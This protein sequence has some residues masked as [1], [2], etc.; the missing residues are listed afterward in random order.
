LVS[1]PAFAS[2][3]LGIITGASELTVIDCDTP[4]RREELEAIFGSADVVVATS[5]GGLHLYYKSNGEHSAPIDIN[6]MKI[7]VKGLGGFV[8]APPST[9]VAAD[10]MVRFYQ[11]LEGGWKW[12]ENLRAIKPGALPKKF[13]GSR[14]S[15]GAPLANKVG[16]GVRNTT[17]FNALLRR[18]K[19][20]E[21]RDE[22]LREATLI[23]DRFAQPLQTREVEAT[24]GSVW[25]YKVEG[26][27]IVPSAPK[28]QIPA[29]ALELLWNTAN[30]ADALMFLSVLLFNHG[31]RARRGEDFA[32]AAEAMQRAEVVK[33][34]GIK[35]YRGA[36]GVLMAAGL[37][38][39]FY[40]GG[41]R[42]GDA[43]RYVFGPALMD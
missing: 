38:I 30:G 16:V 39:Q 4:G 17:L 31:A 36:T 20:S 19:T 13:Y 1:K 15:D 34:W 37:I 12:V 26:Q 6:G 41:A 23:N 40:K 29:S 25:G 5:S 32:I 2:A 24:V 42:R 14:F 9:R 35:R 22:L 43:H 11:F 8:V 21:T 27:L 7:D 28:I 10:G 33:G 3:N 18:A